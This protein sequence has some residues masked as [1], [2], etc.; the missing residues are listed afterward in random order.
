MKGAQSSKR[1]KAATKG[2]VLE[3]EN[4]QNP[5]KLI[6]HWINHRGSKDTLLQVILG[7][8]IRIASLQVSLSKGWK[9]EEI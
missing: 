8:E 5:E 1:A 9:Q 2:L 3:E 7:M 4:K 6:Y